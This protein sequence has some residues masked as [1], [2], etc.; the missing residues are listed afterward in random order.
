MS[1]AQETIVVANSG[2]SSA[3]VL[4]YGTPPTFVKSLGTGST[5]NDIAVCGNQFLTCNQ[6]SN[7][8]SI[9]DATT[10]ELKFTVGST[11]TFGGFA[12]PSAVENWQFYNGYAVVIDSKGINTGLPSSG[13]LRF[14]NTADGT[15][16]DEFRDTFSTSSQYFDVKV[17]GNKRVWVSDRTQNRVV[18]YRFDAFAGPPFGMGT[19]TVYEG[20]LEFVDSVTHATIAN[21]GKIAV[22]GTRVFVTNGNSNFV[23]VLNSEYPANA[24]STSV[25]GTVDV[26]APQTDIAVK[27]GKVYV[28]IGSDIKVIDANNLTVGSTFTTGGIAIGSL[29]T[30]SSNSYL[31]AGTSFGAPT[32]QV[33]QFNTT[34]GLIVSTYSTD[35]SAPSGFAFFQVT[36]TNKKD[37]GKQGTIKCF[38]SRSTSSSETVVVVSIALFFFVGFLFERRR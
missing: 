7:N 18:C 19:Q 28:A 16:I 8:L 35:I 20:V 32:Q 17:S 25:I 31:W 15:S 10:N 14:I 33:Y 3:T 22:S 12:S 30:S 21:P 4:S 1:L 6:G 27:S 11:F 26:G 5:P 13:T 36:V 23:T 2:S 38:A 34:N 24:P 29:G 37:N 9:F